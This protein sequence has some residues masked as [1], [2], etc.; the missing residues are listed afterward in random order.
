MKNAPKSFTVL[1]LAALTGLSF[2]GAA[3]AD[4]NDD[5]RSRS[6]CQGVITVGQCAA[7]RA[8]A[9]TASTLKLRDAIALV[10]SRFGGS[11]VSIEFKNKWNAPQYEASVL[12]ANTSL[13]VVVDARTG[14]VLNS[15]EK[16]D[17]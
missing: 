13:Q 9:Y 8:S 16:C 6:T 7:V 1:F 5:D 2:S 10:E 11:V 3:L 15:R 12:T 17:D 4:K 14:T